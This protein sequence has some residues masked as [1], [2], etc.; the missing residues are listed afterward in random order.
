MRVQFDLCPPEY[1]A[2][3]KKRHSFNAT[4][5][6]AVLLLLAFLA[7][8]IGYI[9]MA[10]LET[11]ALA[12]DIEMGEEAVAKLE[13]DQNELTAEIARLKNREQQYGKT[14]EIM[15]SEPPTIEALSAL[16]SN[17]DQGMG[18]TSIRFVPAK[19][20]E[21]GSVVYTAD[22]DATALVEDQITALT[23]GLSGSGVFSGVTM[24]SSQKDEKTGRVDFK[25][26]LDLRPFGQINMKAMNSDDSAGKEPNPQ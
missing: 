15:Q 17:M 3:R 5:I 14:L 7:T 19:A 10:F 25:L 13:A 24:P 1:L 23:T 22:V 26:H 20:N 11:R 12:S 6:L 9:V 4:R 18:M 21:G 2:R 8:G 16:E